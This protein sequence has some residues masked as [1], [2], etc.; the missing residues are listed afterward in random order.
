MENSILVSYGSLT[1]KKYKG[2]SNI[3]MGV[4]DKVIL[5][6][7]TQTST[8]TPFQSVNFCIFSVISSKRCSD[9]TKKR[10]E[11]IKLN[12]KNSFHFN[13]L[14]TSLHYLDRKRQ[15]QQ[16]IV[17]AI[18]LQQDKFSVYLTLQHT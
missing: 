6:Y 11:K 7:K 17:V 3:N 15:Y 4:Q 1:T 14:A 10:K 5:L 13:F 16:L 18:I 9:N 8:A 12:L 2:N